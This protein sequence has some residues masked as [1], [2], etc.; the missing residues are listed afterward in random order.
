MHYNQALGFF[1]KFG[2][3]F[4]LLSFNYRYLR[5]YLPH[6]R[7]VNHQSI[8]T[9]G[10]L[11]MSRKLKWPLDKFAPYLPY[12]ITK[13]YLR[14]E[15]LN[16]DDKGRVE[17]IY[18]GKPNTQGSSEPVIFHLAMHTIERT[19]Y[20]NKIPLY[21]SWV[22]SILNDMAVIM[23]RP[24]KSLPIKYGRLWKEYIIHALKCMKPCYSTII[25][26]CAFNM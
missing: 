10:P 23:P 2:K 17:S 24:A 8:K 6:I 11:Y 12:T 15:W 21:R 3:N 25:H 20:Q 9:S 22:L 19:T 5:Y 4:L 13:R 26:L 1:D 14:K 18:N 7:L 16:E